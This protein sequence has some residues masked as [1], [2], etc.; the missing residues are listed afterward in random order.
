ML[1]KKL[2]IEGLRG[3]SEKICFEFA[4]P[5][6]KNIGS[7]LTILVG[8]NNSGKSTVIETVHILNSN[9]NSIPKKY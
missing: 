6:G 7:G 2:S 4:L 1:I 5:D 3:F 8:P 9:S